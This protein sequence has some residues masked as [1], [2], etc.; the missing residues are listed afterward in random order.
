MAERG[1]SVLAVI[2]PQEQCKRCGEEVLLTAILAPRGGSTSAMVRLGPLCAHPQKSYWLYSRSEGQEALLS[3]ALRLGTVVEQGV[4][5]AGTSVGF[6]MLPE[7]RE[8]LTAA[9]LRQRLVDL[10][11]QPYGVEAGPEHLG[12]VQAEAVQAEGAIPDAAGA[13]ASAD[14]Q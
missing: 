4:R 3:H 8:A 6:Q 1:R 12:L 14:D 7:E 11:L 5:L 10:Y 9:H 2:G 13:P